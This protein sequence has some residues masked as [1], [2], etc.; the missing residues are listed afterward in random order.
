M[1]RSMILCSISALLQ[2]ALQS[3]S[4]SFA[5]VRPD[6]D[7]Y[8]KQELVRQRNSQQ[9]EIRGS[10]YAHFMAQQIGLVHSGRGCGNVHFPRAWVSNRRRSH[11]G[12]WHPVRRHR[13]GSCSSFRGSYSTL[14]DRS[15]QHCSSIRG[16]NSQTWRLHNTSRSGRR[17]S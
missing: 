7:L 6:H 12:L 17:R 15:T 3:A 2:S 1:L 13:R 5:G 4:Q 16:I 14:S 9:W 10:V 11:L 8:I